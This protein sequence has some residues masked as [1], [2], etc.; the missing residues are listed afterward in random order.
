MRAAAA[1]SMGAAAAAG[2]AATAAAAA[3]AHARRRTSGNANA[4]PTAEESAM[5]VVKRALSS[6]S[7]KFGGSATAAGSTARWGGA[8]RIKLTHNP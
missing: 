2:D 1:R 3:E 6:A 5:N 4:Q 7:S 8:R